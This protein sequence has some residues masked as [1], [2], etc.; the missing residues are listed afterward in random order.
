MKCTRGYPASYWDIQ[1]VKS[2]MTEVPLKLAPAC[3]NAL[4]EKKLPNSRFRRRPPQHAQLHLQAGLRACD[5][6]RHPRRTAFPLI[7]RSSKLFWCFYNYA[8]KQWHSGP[9]HIT[10]RCGGSVGLRPTSRFSHYALRITVC[11]TD[12]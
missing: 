3:T 7:A 12:T 4:T 5:W 8:I 1:E 10:Y 2:M 6:V 9:P 11:V